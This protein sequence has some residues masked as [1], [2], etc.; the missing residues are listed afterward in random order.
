ML[1]REI[2]N[3]TKA[4]QRKGSYKS[5]EKNKRWF[6]QRL[7]KCIDKERGCSVFYKRKGYKA[8]IEVR[9]KAQDVS[10]FLNE[11]KD[12][13]DNE[14]NSLLNPDEKLIDIVLF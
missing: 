12:K 13:L 14:L 3:N 2:K 11:E 7:E 9:I 10:T 8:L 4:R 1:D 6:I 5:V